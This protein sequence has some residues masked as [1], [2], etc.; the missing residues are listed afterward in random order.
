MEKITAE[1]RVTNL[2]VQSFAYKDGKGE[3]IGGESVAI[4]ASGYWIDS[5]EDREGVDHYPIS[6][7]MIVYPGHGIIP[8]LGDNLSITVE[9][10]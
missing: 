4:K 2:N 10:N 9:R 1:V 8:A 6:L 7:H 3:M 5:P